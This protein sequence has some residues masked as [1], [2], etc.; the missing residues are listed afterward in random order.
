MQKSLKTYRK[1]KMV[2]NLQHQI[3]LI[4]F[5]RVG[6]CDILK[7]NATVQMLRIQMSIGWQIGFTVQI[8]KALLRCSD[9]LPHLGIR[10]HNRLEDKRQ[11]RAFVNLMHQH[12]SSLKQSAPVGGNTI[13]N[14]LFCS[15]QIF[16]PHLNSRGKLKL[17]ENERHQ[18]S[19]ANAAPGDQNPSIVQNTNLHGQRGQLEEESKRIFILME[20]ASS[21]VTKPIRVLTTC[22]WV[23]NDLSINSSEWHS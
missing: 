3:I 1:R 16:V 17:I 14:Y 5:S 2:P 21:K 6:K 8:I 19:T 12:A 11:R 9:G 4:T 7:F 13:K 10:R 20:K 18:V 23:I 22:L 15:H